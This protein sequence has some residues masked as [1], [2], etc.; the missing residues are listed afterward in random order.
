[1]SIL[2]KDSSPYRQ[3]SLCSEPSSGIIN[4]GSRGVLTSLPPPCEAQ[5]L[6]SAFLVAM[7]YT[8]EYPRPALTVDCVIFGYENK[9]LKSLGWIICDY[10]AHMEHH[11][12]QIFP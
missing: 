10:V 12:R 4:P 5:P 11:F 6:P 8:Y 3:H 7:P 2:P 9:E 1:M